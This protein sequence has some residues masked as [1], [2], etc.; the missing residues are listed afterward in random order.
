MSLRASLFEYLLQLP[1]RQLPLDMT[2]SDIRN[3]ALKW[4]PNGAPL[5]WI[6]AQQAF[7]KE[8]YERAETY[9]EALVDMGKKQSY[10][11]H[12]SFDPRIVG[13]DALLNLGVCRVRQAKLKAAAECFE[14]L[15]QSG[16]Q[17]KAAQANL[18]VI[19]RFRKR[20]QDPGKKKKQSKTVRK[21]RKKR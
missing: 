2:P 14:A 17:I 8:D 11:R 10:D 5:L 21:R 12:I 19:N 20:Y 4:F 6:L 9:L 7:S 16:L 13:E 3:L 1:K 15:I 18:K